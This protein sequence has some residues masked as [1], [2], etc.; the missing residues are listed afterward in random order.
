VDWKVNKNLLIG[1]LVIYQQDTRSAYG[2][3]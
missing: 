2:G 3:I 1:L